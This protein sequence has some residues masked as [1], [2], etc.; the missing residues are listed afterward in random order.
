MTPR[1]SCLAALCWLAPLAALRADVSLFPLFS[2]HAVLQASDRVPVWGRATPG[3]SVTVTLGGD[4]LRATALTGADGKWTVTLDLSHAGPGPFELVAAG[5]QNRATAT[6]V[7]IG[8]VWLCSGQSNMDFQLSRAADAAEEIP[9]SANPNLR[10][11]S[12]SKV[13]EA[14]PVD[15]VRG[16][17][18]VASPQTSG[19]F[20]AVGYYFGQ[21]V[22]AATGKAVGLISASWG[23]TPVESWTSAEGFAASTDADLR[24]G[25][26]Q[27][28]A[29]LAAQGKY[30]AAYKAWQVKLLRQDHEHPDVTAYTAPATESGGWHRVTLPGTFAAANVPELPDAGAVW[31]QRTV[32]VKRGGGSYGV[33]V[34]PGDAHGGVEVYW[35]GKKLGASDP[36]AP[37]PHFRAN[38]PD[39]RTG[40]NLV[41]MRLFEPDRGAGIGSG[42][43]KF[44]VDTADGSVPLAGPWLAKTE[45]AL[46]TLAAGQEAA[47]VR[48]P[49]PREP[50]YTASFLYNGM[51]APL[52]PCALRGVLWYQGEANA[53]RAQQYRGSFPLMIA[54]WRARWGRGDFPFYWCQLA[55]YQKRHEH[56]DESAWA[57]LREAQTNTL[58]LPNTGQAVLIDIGEEGDIHPKNKRDA[59]DRLARVALAKNYGQKNAAWSGPVLDTM[60]AEAGGAVRLK[61]THADGGLRATPIP[62]DYKPRSAEKETKPNVRNSAGGALEGFA[63]CGE[64]HQWYWAT[65]ADLDGNDGVVV[66]CAEVPAPVAV[67][68][69]WGDTPLCNLANGAGL[70]AGPFRTDDFPLST[71]KGKY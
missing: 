8:E 24:D 37:L 29:K 60:K 21:K 18:E 45:F 40:D 67:R 34:L 63:V 38:G 71:A 57:E 23:G 17:W 28:R 31:V 7:L 44:Q 39:V 56:P 6:D 51:I 4:Q 25:A 65:T 36:T 48:P 46:P 33:E 30:V 66:R 58:R 2:D 13:A 62:S 68:Y 22:Q 35:N 49:T 70:P 1:L 59:G 26:A 9:R 16:R 43:G 19:S 69:A 61:F 11:F 14:A 53:P 55:N 5:P 3:E 64:D 32:N 42:S 50:P 15:T 12:V 47:P 27:G 54:D 20:T 52:V 41:A 10:Q